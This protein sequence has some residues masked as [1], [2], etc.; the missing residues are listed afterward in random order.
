[1]TDEVVKPARV[2]DRKL[3]VLVVDSLPRWDFKFLQRALLRDRRV[4]ARFFLTEGDRQTMKAGP[5]WVPGFGVGR[6]AV[7]KEVFEYDLLILGD[8]PGSF[9]TAD[10]QEVIKDFVSEGGG[11]V[12]IA[13]RNHAPAGWAKAPLADVLPVEFDAVQFPIESP[14]RPTPY[15]P[16]VVQA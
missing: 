1:L 10:Q 5:P 8:L 12:H 6:E 9:W 11:L 16:R 4:E 15:R 14:R 2:V 3:K 7:R 13:G